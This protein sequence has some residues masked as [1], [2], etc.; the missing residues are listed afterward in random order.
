MEAPKSLRLETAASFPG[1]SEKQ[2]MW[3]VTVGPLEDKP[4][5]SPHSCVATE[6]FQCSDEHQPWQRCDS[7]THSFPGS[8]NS[9]LQHLT[10]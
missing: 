1:T 10:E 8:A 2:E 7:F 4:G 6:E 3:E 5:S 9:G